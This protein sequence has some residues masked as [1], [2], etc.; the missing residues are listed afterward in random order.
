MSRAFFAL[1]L[2][3]GTFTA[4][5][6]GPPAPEVIRLGERVVVL[7]GLEELPDNRNLGLI[8][9]STL[10]IGDTGAILIDSGFTHEIGLALR[11]AAEKITPK[12]ITH[13]INTHAHGDHFLGNTAFPEA[14]VISSEKCRDAVSREGLAAV[15]LIESLTGRLSPATKPVPATR[16]Y[17]ENT[18]S[19]VR[20]NGVRM[21]LWVPRG[22]HTPGDLMVYLPDDGILVASDVLA[23]GVVPNLRDGHVQAWLRTLD[24]V[25]S[26]TFS[27]AIPGHGRPMSKAEVS[28]FAARLTS[29]Y[30]GIEAGYKRGLSDSEIRE[31]L[32]LSEWAKLR[33]FEEMGMAIN[34][35]YLEVERENF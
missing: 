11:R 31:Q 3:F 21:E 8:G 20:I 14:E 15:T 16:T 28:A 23:N 19:E 32:D 10:V 22:S 4:A 17:A 30:S 35:I 29:L 18:R 33:R 2:L 13:V 7:L 1:M 26:K 25:Q 34:R 12:P 27:S 24:E 5:A 9:N 6:G